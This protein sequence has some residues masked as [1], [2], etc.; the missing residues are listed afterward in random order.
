MWPQHY[1]R[2][3][4]LALALVLGGWS[5][6]GLERLRGSVDRAP[7]VIGETP[8]TLYAGRSDDPQPVVVMAHG[9][10]GSRQFMEALALTVARAGYPVLS[11][12]L[13]GHGRNP[14]RMSPGSPHR[15]HDARFDG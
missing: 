5:W 7:M 15:G 13:L 8:A 14:G 1:T 12:D 10:A 2:W 9:F 4:V 11:Y 6:W 3:G